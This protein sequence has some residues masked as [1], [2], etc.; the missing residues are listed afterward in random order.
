MCLWSGEEGVPAHKPGSESCLPCPKPSYSSALTTGPARWAAAAAPGS[1]CFSLPSWPSRPSAETLALLAASA[2]KPLAQPWAEKE[3][4]VSLGT[5][6]GRGGRAVL[7]G[8]S[9]QGGQ[10]T[11]SSHSPDLVL[12]CLRA[13][14]HLGAEPGQPLALLLSH[15]GLLQ[16]RVQAPRLPYFPQLCSSNLG[17]LREPL[18]SPLGSW[19]DPCLWGLYRSSFPPPLR[20]CAV[21]P[22]DLLLVHLPFHHQV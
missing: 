5:C 21:D 16:R 22:Q 10:A 4:G 8:V 1:A 13:G 12:I 20:I 17:H 9:L 2:G 6:V 3:V 11:H 18:P 7:R 15:L 14:L 19:S